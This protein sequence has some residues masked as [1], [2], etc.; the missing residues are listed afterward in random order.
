MR[1]RWVGAALLSSWPCAER[2]LGGSPRRDPCAE[3]SPHS[4]FPPPPRPSQRPEGCFLGGCQRS[5]G[6]GP[7]WA[8]GRH[9]QGKAGRLEVHG[10][11]AAAAM[12]RGQGHDRSAPHCRDA[13]RE[14][15]L[16]HNLEAPCSEPVTPACPRGSVSLAQSCPFKAAPPSRGSL[17]Q[18]PSPS[19]YSP[20][21]REGLLGKE[22]GIF[23]I[24][25]DAR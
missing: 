11:E 13:F 1:G 6:E 18:P 10:S 23:L 24:H 20:T 7:P 19:F 14:W 22:K 15:M 9:V 17:P 25:E 21:F 12:C 3:P 4:S 16:R 5:H 2:R 8:K